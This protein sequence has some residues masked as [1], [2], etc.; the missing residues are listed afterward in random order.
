MKFEMVEDSFWIKSPAKSIIVHKSFVNL[1][2]N[3][4]EF[5]EKLA[6]F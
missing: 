5:A 4:I 2:L 1:F 3:S 6:G